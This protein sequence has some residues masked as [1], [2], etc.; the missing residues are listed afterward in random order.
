MVGQPAR[1]RDDNVGLSGEL[2]RLRHHV[3]EQR[4]SPVTG[5]RTQTLEPFSLYR[6]EKSLSLFP[7]ASGA[8]TAPQRADN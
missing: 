8:E 6:W 5:D 1:R 4:Q 7:P 2:Q 3:C